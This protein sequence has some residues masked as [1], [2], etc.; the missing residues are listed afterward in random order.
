MDAIL[1]EAVRYIAISLA[2]LIGV[3]SLTLLE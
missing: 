3:L 1:S 2:Y